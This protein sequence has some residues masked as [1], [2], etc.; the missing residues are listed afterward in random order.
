MDG[1]EEKIRKHERG[2]GGAGN[3]QNSPTKTR[4]SHSRE[5]EKTLGTGEAPRLE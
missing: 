5:E 3:R 4:T 2:Y 1:A